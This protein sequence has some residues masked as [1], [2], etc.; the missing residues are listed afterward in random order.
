MPY[1]VTTDSDPIAMNR[2]VRKGQ[3]V[4]FTVTVTSVPD[5]NGWP[6][7]AKIFNSET[8]K[9]L[10]TATA[11]ATANVATFTFSKETIQALPIGTHVAKCFIEAPDGTPWVP[12]QG[13][14]QIRL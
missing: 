7:A 10:A 8:G 5:L 4:S 13:A 2:I 14:W 9:E 6:I 12:L 3:A 1:T 11:T